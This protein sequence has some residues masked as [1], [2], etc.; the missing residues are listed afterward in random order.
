LFCFPFSYFLQFLFC[1]LKKLHF[2][3]LNKSKS[4]HFLNMK[5]MCFNTLTKF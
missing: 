4:V 5:L 2:F 1:C 3:D